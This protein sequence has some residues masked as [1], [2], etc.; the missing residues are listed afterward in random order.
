MM[1]TN[2]LKKLNYILLC[3]ILI[4]CASGSKKK[5]D[6]LGIYLF[7]YPSGEIE[8]LE[9]QESLYRKL[10]FTNEEEYKKRLQPKYINEG[11]WS[12]NGNELRF[13]QWLMYCKMG[14]PSMIQNPPEV[15]TVSSAYWHSGSFQLENPSISIFDES[16]YI[17]FKLDNKNFFLQN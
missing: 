7:T 3:F 1:D 11:S 9:L 5:E 10:I 17:F 2:I 13:N 12:I 14:Y 8:I 4:S 15:T 16:G 6:V